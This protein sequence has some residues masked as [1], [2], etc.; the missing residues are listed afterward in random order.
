MPT[1]LDKTAVKVAKI[2]IFDEKK[3]V[4]YKS[5]FEAATVNNVH[6]QDISRCCRKNE[7]AGRLRYRLKDDYYI[8]YKD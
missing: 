4:V 6:K 7:K 2:S 5:V 8:Y 3:K 1:I